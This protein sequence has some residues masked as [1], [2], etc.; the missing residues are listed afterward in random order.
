MPKAKRH[1]STSNTDTAFAFAFA[2]KAEFGNLMER[3]ETP[4]AK[5]VKVSGIKLGV[6]VDFNCD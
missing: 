4:A 1:K 5:S 2:G 3:V 6:S